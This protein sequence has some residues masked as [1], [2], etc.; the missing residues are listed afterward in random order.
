MRFL[1]LCFAFSLFAGIE[2][3][4]KKMADK[5]GCI[6]PRNIDYVYMINLDQRPERW[7]RATKDLAAYAIFPERFSGI[8]GWTI[9]V[10]ALNDISLKFE[11]GMWSGREWVMVFRPEKDGMPDFIWLDASWYG[12]SCFSGW[13]VKGTIGCSLSH[14]SVLKDAYDSGYETV[15]ILE[16]DI[17]IHEDPHLLSDRIEELDE[18]VG[19]DGWD[20]LYTDF[21]YLV[22]DPSRTLAEQI[23]HMW[24]P[25]M[26][27]LDIRFLAEH[28][29]LGETFM[30]I[31]SRFRAH[32]I[33]YRRAGIEKILNFYRE[34]NNFLPYDQELALV[35][36][37]RT[38]VLKKPIVSYNQV[39]SDTR[40]R[41]FPE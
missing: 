3:H 26:A 7:N 17:V 6:P 33:L 16:D 37:I 21:D 39:D 29:D 10:D 18:L 35:P 9:P 34:R 23:P 4:Y 13:T 28:T 22:V 24:R 25:D 19:P 2:D 15:W 1:L 11:P 20:V 31:G 30:R 36:G 41:Y 40:Y 12:K 27:G 14:L 38:F 5:K 32:S 8:Y